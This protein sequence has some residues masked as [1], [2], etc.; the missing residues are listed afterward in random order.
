MRRLAILALLL[1]TAATAEA[2][3][4][5]TCGGDDD[6]A[7][8]LCAYQRR[9]FPAAESGFRAIVDRNDGDA[10]TIRSIY[11]LA[12]TEMKLG[13]F[14]E[15]SPLFIRIYSMDPSFYASWNCD[16]LLGECRRASGKE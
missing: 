3:P 13:R 11:F 6:Y 2:K 8:A 4:P 14:D 9:D 15:A 1:I 16:F 10:Q 5:T 7:K 12:R